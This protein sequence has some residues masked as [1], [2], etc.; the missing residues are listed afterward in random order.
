MLMGAIGC[1]RDPEEPESERSAGG[2][3]VDDAEESFDEAT[4][5]LDDDADHSTGESIDEAT[6]DLDDN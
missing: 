3:A 1:K 4:E 6:E 2:E 5:D